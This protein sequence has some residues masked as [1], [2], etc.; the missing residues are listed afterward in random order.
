MVQPTVSHLMLPWLK[1]GATAFRTSF[2]CSS[3]GPVSRL[4]PPKNCARARYYLTLP[5]LSTHVHNMIR[6]MGVPLVAA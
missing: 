4:V 2:Q 6:Y 3:V 1:A 5:L